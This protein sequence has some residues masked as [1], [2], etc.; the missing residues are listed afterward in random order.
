[1]LREFSKYLEE[2]FPDLKQQRLLIACSGGVD[3]V[4]QARL[5]HKLEYQIALAHC[6]FGLRGVESD[7]DEAFVR[8]LAETLGCPF[9][10]K[11]FDTKAYA[12]EQGLSTQMAARDLRYAW[13]EELKLQQYD[14]LL[15]AHHADDDLETFLIHLSRG[16]GLKGMTSIPEQRHWILRPFLSYPKETLLEY[17]KKQG[18]PWREDSSNLQTDY[19]RNAIRLEV[20]PKLKEVDEDILDSFKQTKSHLSESQA[21]IDD[22]LLLIQQLLFQETHEGLEMDL[23]KWADLPN[24]S[25]LLNALF[26]P[27]GFTDLSALHALPQAQSGKYILAPEYRLLRDRD[28]LILQKK[29]EKEPNEVFYIGETEKNI[30]KPIRLSVKPIGKVGYHDPSAIYVDRALLKYPLLIRKWREGDRFQ[31][32]G[33]KGNKKISKFLKDEKLSLAAKEKLWLLCSEDRIVW[34][35][36]MRADERFKV[37]PATEEILKITYYP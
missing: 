6:N 22:Y 32:F 36:G 12:A 3:S 15:T 17:A 25:A 29:V 23:I 1:M 5:L 8:E 2:T 13:F 30:E 11:K 14:R 24:N 10:V 18:W 35:I 16:S 27:Y 20:I 37:T 4:V 33:M 19:L 26:R 31:P 28:R 34:V 21:L 9:H 7:A